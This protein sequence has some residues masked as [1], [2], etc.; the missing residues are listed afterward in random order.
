[1][2]AYQR[3]RTSTDRREE[4]TAAEHPLELS[5][6]VAVLQ[7][8]DPCMRRVTR[9][10][11]DA[12]MSIR[13]ARDLGQVGDRDDLGAIAQPAKGLADSVR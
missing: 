12:E 13:K 6:P 9:N 5:A 8:L 1:M 4:L 7:H 11:L 10:L 2:Q 3:P